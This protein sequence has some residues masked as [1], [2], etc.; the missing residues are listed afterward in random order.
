MSTIRETI[1]NAYAAGA[2][3]ER[4]LTTE[5]KALLKGEDRQTAR[6]E[7]SVRQAENRPRPTLYAK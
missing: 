3:A 5:A 6:K 1:E 2:F 4:G 7:S